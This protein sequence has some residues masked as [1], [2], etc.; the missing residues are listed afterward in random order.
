MYYLQ[1]NLSILIPK[2]ELKAFCEKNEIPYRTLQDIKS[3]H[4]LYPRIDIVIK[5]SQIFKISIDS[6]VLNDLSKNKNQ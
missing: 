3:G 1:K 2:R 4:T 5:L 6:L